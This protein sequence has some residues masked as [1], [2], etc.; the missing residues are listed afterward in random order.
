MDNKLVTA[1]KRCGQDRSPAPVFKS[2][3]FYVDSIQISCSTQ[4]DSPSSFEIGIANY[5]G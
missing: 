5:N 2:R 1:I 3:K 4:I